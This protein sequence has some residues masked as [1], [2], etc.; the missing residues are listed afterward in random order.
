MYSSYSN[1]HLKGCLPKSQIKTAKEDAIKA[2]EKQVMFI[3]V[4]L[5]SLL[6]LLHTNGNEM[7]CSVHHIKDCP[8]SN[9]KQLTG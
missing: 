4:I 1:D 5:K 6:I 3:P 2:D 8:R 7:A 9:C